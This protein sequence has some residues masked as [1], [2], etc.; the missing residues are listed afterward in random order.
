MVLVKSII[1]QKNIR[2]TLAEMNLVLISYPFV[3]YM[4]LHYKFGKFDR[5]TKRQKNNRSSLF[6]ASV[7][8]YLIIDFIVSATSFIEAV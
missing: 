8:C 2:F 6:A 3:K 7:F 4:P 1:L 5:T